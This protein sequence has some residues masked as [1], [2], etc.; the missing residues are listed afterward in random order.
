MQG[1][2]KHVQANQSGMRKAAAGAILASGLVLSGCRQDMHN[3]P[4]F[5][6]QRGTTFFA[7][8]RSSRPQVEETV[9]RGQLHEDS[10]FYSGLQ[11]GQEGATMPFPVT[12]TVLARGQE[13]YNLYCTPCHSR[14]GNGAGMIVQRGYAKAGNFHT[15]RLQN[16]PLG[17]FFTVI[18]NGY[19]AMPDY[20]AQLTPVDRWAVVAYIRALQLSQSAQQSDVAGGQHVQPLTDISVAEG[21]PAEFG[22]EWALPPTAVTGTPNGEPYVLP[23][24]S[25]GGTGAAYGP[26]PSLPQGVSDPTNGAGTGQTSTGYPRQLTIPN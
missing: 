14:V 13:R 12:M 23:P 17:H 7:D 25:N 8:G 19:G 9:A 1:I 3:Q 6:P 11:N 22:A 5:I 2:A 21:F 26:H 10:Y 16:A 15:A 20:S 24:S 18:S 4:K